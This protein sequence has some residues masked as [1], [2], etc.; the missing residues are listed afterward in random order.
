MSPEVLKDFA[1]FFLI[2]K[3]C[4]LLTMHEI[5]GAA[6]NF[7]PYSRICEVAEGKEWGWVGW[8]G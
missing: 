7:G 5:R 4:N 6:I 3:S 1:V 8:G 2:H